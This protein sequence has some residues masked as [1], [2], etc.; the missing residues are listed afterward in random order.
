M[1]EWLKDAP[2]NQRPVCP[3]DEDHLSRYFIAETLLSKRL[4]GTIS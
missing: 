1:E 2:N 4:T 3:W